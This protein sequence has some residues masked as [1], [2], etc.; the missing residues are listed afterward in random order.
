MAKKKSLL[1]AD[2]ESADYM[3]IISGGGT[4]QVF[5]KNELA[6]YSY[7]TGIAILD[8]ALAYEIIIRDETNKI[9]GK[10]ICSG[11][12]AG[13]F[14]VITGKTQSFKTTLAVQMI[15]NIAY[16]NG[17]NVLHY[18]AENRITLERVKQLSKLPEE[19][20]SA[21][22]PRYSLRK[23]AIGYNTLQN[24]ITE[25]YENK[26]RY[27]D[28]ITKPVGEVDCRNHPI[29]LMPPT[30]VFVDSLQNLISDDNSY[31][32]NSKNFDNSKELRSNMYGA[33]SAKTIR[34]LITDIIPM[35][36]E[37]NIILIV[38][39]H[40][41]SNVAAS[42]FAP[43]A[44]QFQYGSNNERTSGGSA[45]EYNA[46][47]VINLTGKVDADSRF[48]E[49]TDGFDGNTVL[50]EQTKA[51]TNESGN[52]KTGL[53]FEFIIDKKRNGI[54]NVRSLIYFLRDRGRIKGNKAGYKVIDKNG[55]EIS[56]KF[57]WK[58][59]YDDFSKSPESYKAFMLTAKEELLKLVSDSKDVSGTIRPFN[60][61]DIIDG[62]NE[63]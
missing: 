58:T 55:E 8:Y 17:G 50:Y 39:A 16:A 26:M 18:D 19:W 43:V 35:L 32:V 38:I 21:E 52:V 2:L 36:R 30:M 56:T 37:A 53:G 34:G 20:F 15:S 57:T 59:V 25:I 12:Q 48:F 29:E 40:K 9:V 61:D 10:R 54:D 27:K 42:P 44:K 41:T 28:V 31:D 51:S 49:E 3:T 6:D 62:F 5:R 4:S 60:L 23:G 63:N 24:D 46:S 11:L 45:V 13:S 22:Y 14:N 1:Q 47:A 33:Q 7:S